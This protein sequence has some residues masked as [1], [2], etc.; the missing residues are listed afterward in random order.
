MRKAFTALATSV[1]ALL[2]VLAVPTPASASV[3]LLTCTG[4]YQTSYSPGLTYT[5]QAVH[6]QTATTYACLLGG[7]VTSG[8]AAL[9]ADLPAASC[10]DL[11]GSVVTG[12]TTVTWNT[13]E[14]TTYSWSS[15][16]VNVLGTLVT[17]TVGQVTAG[18]YLGAHVQRVTISPN[19]QALINA[20]NSG[21]GLTQEAGTAVLTLQ[22]L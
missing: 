18:K 16:A 7:T 8:N 1:L 20:C 11:L 5:P 14:T 6:Y 17:T 4:T 21:T 12:S 2:A 10:V 19:L 3:T 15:T 9:V 13:G 22:Q